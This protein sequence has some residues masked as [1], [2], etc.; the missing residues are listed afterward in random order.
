MTKYKTISE[1][2][3]NGKFIASG[4]VVEGINLDK[5]Y[6][7]IF[8]RATPQESLTATESLKVITNK[9][10]A[11]VMEQ[12]KAYAL[13]EL[14]SQITEAVMAKVEEKIEAALTEK[15]KA[16]TTAAPDKNGGQ[17]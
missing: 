15:I 2:V 9:E 12:V 3:W 1:T 10:I 5:T 4:T 11:K 17:A 8:R 7:K 14:E 16:A 13:S 6:P